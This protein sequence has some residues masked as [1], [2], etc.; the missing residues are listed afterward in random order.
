M[1]VV[2]HLV[3]PRL[4]AEEAIRPQRDEPP[5]LHDPLHLP[6]ELRHIKP[7]ERLRHRHELHR[8][9]GERRVLRGHCGIL[10]AFVR[11]RV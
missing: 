9:P 5:G 4:D 2:H 7:V 3:D 8:R 10:H 6:V 11:T 1:E